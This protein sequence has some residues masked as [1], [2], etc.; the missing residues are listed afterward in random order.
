MALEE[1]EK[2]KMSNREMNYA[3]MR[4]LM[5]FGMG[6]LWTAMGL[7]LLLKNRLNSSIPINMDDGV[8]QIF[9][10]VCLVY[11]VFRIYR[12]IKKNYFK[13]FKIN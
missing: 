2:E 13:K 10:G 12:G 9:G 1:F 8:A 4:S 11:G 3:R 7:F 5:D 6:L